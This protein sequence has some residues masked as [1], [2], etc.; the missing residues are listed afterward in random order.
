MANIDAWGVTDK[1]FYRPTMED[2]IT[3]K[4]KQ[5]KQIFGEDFDTSELTPQGKF[6]CICA[7][8]ESKLC[9]IAEDI[10]Y[11]FS[12]STARGISLDRV[13]EFVNLTRENERYAVQ[14]IKVFAPFG[15]VV[16]AGMVFKNDAGITFYSSKDEQ[17]EHDA[18]NGLYYAL[19]DVQCTESGTV[20]NV[21]DI[22]D[23]QGVNMNINAVT[24][25]Y[26]VSYGTPLESDYDLR[27]KFNQ[28]V[29]GIG[30]NTSAAIRANVLRVEGVND[31]IIIDNNTPDDISA[32]SLTVA[33][34]SYAVIVHSDSKEIDNDIARAIFEKHPLGVI[35]SGVNTVT[36]KDEANIEHSMKFSYVET[37]PININVECVV[38]E[39]FGT[40]TD[41][42]TE[43]KNSVTSY[44]NN[45][46]IGETV[47]Y[48][49]LYDYIHNVTGV[50]DITN[51]TI[52]SGSPNDGRV[53]IPIDK[54]KIAKVGNITINTSEV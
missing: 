51:V 14:N 28:V 23:T 27:N 49:R 31:V 29:Q 21:T 12:P 36:V 53:N 37:Q 45:L 46:G 26:T 44:I 33:S 32:G 42:V 24:W 3:E 13:C 30:T 18:G 52:T 2:I 10:Y 47:I 43:I 48:S 8:A 40:F 11:S 22:N 5:A 41:G 39:T 15:Y 17:V 19:V 9:E 54:L 1:G 38:D 25:N 20:G 7:A 16:P 34:G 4:N 6:F 35:Q 50:Y